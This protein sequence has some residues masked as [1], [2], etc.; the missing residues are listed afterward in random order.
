MVNQPHR[1]MS[2]RP[3][4]TNATQHN[5]T[6]LQLCVIFGEC[7]HVPRGGWSWCGT[8][9]PDDDWEIRMRNTAR[10]LSRTSSIA[11]R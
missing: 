10:A 11:P 8:V 3:T 5:I 9:Q 1:R 2:A 6:L 7:V 4:T